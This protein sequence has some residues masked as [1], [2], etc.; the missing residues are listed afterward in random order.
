MSGSLPIAE[1]TKL[2]KILSQLECESD[3]VRLAA[4]SAATTILQQN[5]LRWCQISIAPEA[6]VIYPQ[7]RKP[8]D[9]EDPLSGRDWRKVSANCRKHIRYVNAWEDAFLRDIVKRS[10][11]SAKQRE[12]LVGIVRRLEVLG[13]V[14]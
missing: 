12:K 2:H 11:L 1:R 3:G 6:V 13:C 4:I 9:K 8:D 7:F 10:M 14:V 5:G